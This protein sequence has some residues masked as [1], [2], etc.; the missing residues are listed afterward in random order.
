[1]AWRDQLSGI[2]I[3]KGKEGMGRWRGWWI[4]LFSPCYTS[5]PATFTQIAPPSLQL[6]QLASP[7]SHWLWLHFSEVRVVRFQRHL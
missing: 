2:A 6:L 3:R 4:A 1:M 7:L 5:Q